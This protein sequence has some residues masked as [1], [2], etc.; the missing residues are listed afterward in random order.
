MLDAPDV[1][2]PIGIC[3]G[4][5]LATLAYTACRVGELVTLRVGSYRSSG[6][7]KVLDI[8]GKGSKERVVPVAPAA[9]ERIEQW[10]DAAGIRD[11]LDEP[12]FRP[13]ATAR[14]Q[15]R[16]GFLPTLLTR[17]AVQYLVKRY[18]RVLGLDPAVTV[19]SFRVT[20]LTT[21]REQGVDI[22]DLQDFAGHADP[23]TTLGYIRSRDRLSK[24]PAYVLRY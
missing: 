7:H 6:G 3:D 19:H 12:L 21:A 2:S 14:G 10:L 1:A 22:I 16:D 13:A 5:I 11:H 23:R 15:G 8:Y 24:S 4:A 17:R 9:F 20:A 18:A